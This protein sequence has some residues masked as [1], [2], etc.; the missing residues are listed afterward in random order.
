MTYESMGSIIAAKRK[1]LGLT[2]KELADRLGITD[3][4]VSKW[5]RDVC[6]PDTALLAPLAEIL[7]VSLEELVSAKAAPQNGHRGADYFVDLVLKV[8]P[9]AMGVAVTVTSIL[10][11]LDSHSGF[12]MLGLGLAA[13]GIRALKGN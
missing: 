3:K 9:L 8:I 12:I 11:A 7:G 13:T 2:Q 6:C 1:E 10:G 5:E 4:A